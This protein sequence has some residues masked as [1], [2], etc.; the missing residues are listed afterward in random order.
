MKTFHEGLGGDANGA[1]LDPTERMKPLDIVK[2]LMGVYSDRVNVKKFQNDGRFWAKYT[3]Y[4]YDDLYSVAEST[5]KH[6]YVE[7]V[8]GGNCMA[9]GPSSHNPSKKRKVE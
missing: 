5:V 7:L 9:S 6:F 8:T 2:V 4:G 3:E 1:A